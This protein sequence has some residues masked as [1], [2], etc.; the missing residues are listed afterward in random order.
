MT[1]KVVERRPDDVRELTWRLLVA[2][3]TG[4][5]V[6]GVIG[7]I[8]G[9]L[10]MFVLRLGS[11]DAVIGSTTDDGFTIGIFTSQSLFLITVTM[12][13]G[14][15]TGVVYF[16]IRSALPRRGLAEDRNVPLR[17]SSPFDQGGDPL[18]DA[19]THGGEAPSSAPPRHLVKQRGHDARP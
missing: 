15:A 14:A 3:G 18:P 2:T 11:S 5:L 1:Q 10:V 8:G 4:A 7:G 19:D 6:G 9:R 13:I 17:R 12:G 16:I